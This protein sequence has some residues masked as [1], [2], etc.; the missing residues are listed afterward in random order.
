MLYT[1]QVLAL[2]MGLARWPLGDDLPLVGEARSASCGSRLRVG[3]A[4]DEAGAIARIGLSAQACAIGQA[5]ASV[6]AQAAIGRSAADMAQAERAIAAWLE[7]GGSMPDWPGLGDLAPVR[8][9]PGRYGA[10]M[11]GWRAALAGFGAQVRA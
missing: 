3:L 7:H 1:P 4:L 2:A 8:D 9:Y 11:L 5:A 6:M 10:F